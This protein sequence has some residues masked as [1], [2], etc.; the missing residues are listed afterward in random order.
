MAHQGVPD[1]FI[2]DPSILATLADR[3]IL[4]PLDNL[5]KAS[6]LDLNQF[7]ANSITD[8]R[9]ST[10]TRTVGSGNLY[11]LPLTND[12]DEIFFNQTAFDKA[13][14]AYP[15]DGWTWNQLRAAAIRLTLDDHGRNPTQPGF[16]A[17]HIAQ[18]GLNI[19]DGNRGIL[20]AIEDWG[21]AIISPD[22][23]HSV[24]NQ[25]KAVQAISFLASSTR[26]M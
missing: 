4:M 18:Y 23:T 15:H 7:Y 8:S 26:C 19:N 11:A 25:P 12:Q 1:V 10:A 5:V 6:G 17:N 24:I 14:V 16:D 13:Q 21:G 2:M 3:G 9:Y 20:E 22:Y